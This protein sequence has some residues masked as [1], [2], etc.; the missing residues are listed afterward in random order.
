[1][2][3]AEFT[4][5][6]DKRHGPDFVIANEYILYPD[7][8]WRTHD[9]ST[10]FDA[11]ASKDPARVSKYKKWFWETKLAVCQ[12]RFNCCKRN[13]LSKCTRPGSI[14]A[15]ADV[16]VLEEL[17]VDVLATKKQLDALVE[18]CER[19]SESEIQKVKDLQQAM[20]TANY[21]L[22]WA[23]KDYNEAFAKGEDAR[24]LKQMLERVELCKQGDKEAME[25]FNDEA[26]PKAR[27]MLMEERNRQ[28]MSTARSRIEKIEV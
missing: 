2:N 26:S 21:R 9:S 3:I 11:V 23:I 28:E 19:V 27:A 6:F 12:E 13:L 22:Q 14:P 7:G 24:L 15:A 18:Q 17:R 25:K 1:M 5:D 16:Q 4:A 20:Q 10:T 8:S